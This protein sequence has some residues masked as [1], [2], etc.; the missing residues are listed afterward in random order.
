MEKLSLPGD[1]TGCT[2]KQKAE[3][4][5]SRIVVQAGE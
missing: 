2:D 3:V 1:H 4:I 5:V